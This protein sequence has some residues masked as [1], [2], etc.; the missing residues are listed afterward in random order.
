MSDPIALSN[1]PSAYTVPDQQPATSGQF[2]QLT[3]QAQQSPNQMPDPATASPDDTGKQSLQERNIRYSADDEFVSDQENMIKTATQRLEQH[4]QTL[5]TSKNRFNSLVMGGIASERTTSKRADAPLSTNADHA[6]QSSSAMPDSEDITPS[7]ATS[8]ATVKQNDSD[9]P[10]EAATGWQTNDTSQP[11]TSKSTDVKTAARTLGTN[12]QSETRVTTST[13]TTTLEII[14]NQAVIVPVSG[15]TN[16]VTEI[17]TPSE[18]MPA[19]EPIDLQKATSQTSLS[20]TE[21]GSASYAESV[22]Q[23]TEASATTDSD[24]PASIIHSRKFTIAYGKKHKIYTTTEMPFSSGVDELKRQLVAAIDN[25]RSVEKNKSNKMIVQ[26]TSRIKAGEDEEGTE[27][28]SPIYISFRETPK[29]MIK[30]QQRKPS[31]EI[32][33]FMIS[34]LK[35]K[36]KEK[37][38]SYAEDNL[39]QE[40]QLMEDMALNDEDSS[41]SVADARQT[42]ENEAAS[43]LPGADSPANT[44]P[45][46]DKSGPDNTEENETRDDTTQDGLPQEDAV[47]GD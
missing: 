5:Q 24:T 28:V 22:D 16:L 42:R 3:A 46:E 20:T 35:R 38:K 4:R 18:T 1:I 43:N 25:F 39:A 33:E 15:E 14:H 47:K 6:N 31:T 13:V 41:G 36:E 34:E 9:R 30:R 37:E 40:G 27:D 23:Q 11:D 45:E 7:S 10:P 44:Q 29:S 21:Y 26:V 19:A 2:Q 8:V 17:I 12:D 32:T